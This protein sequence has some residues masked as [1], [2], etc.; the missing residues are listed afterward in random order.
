MRLLGPEHP[1]HAAVEPPTILFY[2]MGVWASATGT[3][4]PPSRTNHQI[5]MDGRVPL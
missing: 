2:V 5:F 3:T 1:W 4:E